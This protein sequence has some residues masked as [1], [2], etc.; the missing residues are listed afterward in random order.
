VGHGRE[1]IK[2]YISPVPQVPT[3]RKIKKKKKK[4]D[5]KGRRKQRGREGGRQQAVERIAG[6]NKQRRN[7]RVK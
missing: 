1:D 3:I 4:K 2:N 5:V 7:K 6:K